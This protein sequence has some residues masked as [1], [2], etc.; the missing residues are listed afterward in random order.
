MEDSDYIIAIN[1]DSL[2]PIFNVADVGIV[3]DFKKILPE[4]T[5]AVLAEKTAGAR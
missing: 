5:K 1:K 3:G 4:L 2:A